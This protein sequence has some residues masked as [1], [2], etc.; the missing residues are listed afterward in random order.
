VHSENLYTPALLG[1]LLVLERARADRTRRRWAQAGMALGAVNL[2]RPSAF[3]LPVALAVG[4]VVV[5]RDRRR[6]LRSAAVLGAASLLTIAPWTVQNA[7]RYDTFLPLSTS[8]AVLWQGS[9]EYYDLYQDGRSYLSIWDNE[10]NPAENGGHLP[11]SIDGD[12]WFT[13]RA[14]DS[15]RDR[16]LVYAEYSAQKA[17][18]YW[19]GH[20]SADWYGGRFFS[21]RS[22]HRYWPWWEVVWILGSR[23]LP[24]AGAVALGLT[25]RD[26]RR[27][28]AVYAVLGYFT[29]LHAL[30]WAELRLNE[31][32]LPLV[33]VLVG[34]AAVRLWSPRGAAG[35]AG[36]AQGSAALSATGQNGATPTIGRLSGVPP[37]EPQNVASPNEN[38][39]PS[40]ATSQ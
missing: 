16:P 40:A 35:A 17:L 33:A 21:P 36:P 30:L 13:R 24:V 38:T 11:G 37:V 27:L 32:M 22:L 4:L 6:A 8:V 25:L 20:P 29:V 39:P 12:R 15:I 1:F 2:I 31:P 7:V 23:L 26:R 3:G 18:W 10:L 28:W 5:D 34:A 19:V 9:P 14:L